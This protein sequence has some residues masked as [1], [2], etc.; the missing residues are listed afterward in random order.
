MTTDYIETKLTNEHNT[1]LGKLGRVGSSR[2]KSP[3]AKRDFSRFSHGM[4]WLELQK[5][6]KSTSPSS[7]RTGTVASRVSP[8]RLEAR[9]T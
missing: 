7:R 4:A 8:V 9:P 3:S 5:W 1:T 2:V 6:A